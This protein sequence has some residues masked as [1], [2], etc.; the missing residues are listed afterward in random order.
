MQP[1]E[2]DE[3]VSR[4]EA[5]LVAAELAAPDG[6]LDTSVRKALYGVAYLRSICSQA[7][8]TMQATEADSDVLAIDCNVNT[9]KPIYEYR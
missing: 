5:A 4:S 8:I 2:S 9:R 6:R 1:A 3:T 7:G